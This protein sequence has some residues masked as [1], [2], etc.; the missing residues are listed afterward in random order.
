[1]KKRNWLFILLALVILVGAGMGVYF[2]QQNAA[3]A[4]AATASETTM[5]T[6]AA[7]VGDIT[8][9]ASGAGSIT[10]ATQISLGFEDNG[11]LIELLVEV[12]DKVEKG[13]VMARSQTNQ[14]QESID[15]SIA[16]AVLSILNAQKKLDEL[17]ATA[18]ISRTNAM[19]DITTY[20]QKVRDAQYTLENYTMPTYLQGM[21]AIDAL[22]LMKSNLDA[23]SAAFQP[24]RLYSA[25][26]PVREELL[27]DLAEAQSAYDAAVKRLDYEIVLQVA[28]ANLEKARL[29]Y[30]KYNDGPAA[31]E[32]AI[33]NA[34]L[35]N[36]KAK[37]A[38]AQQAQAV[39]ELIS[40]MDATVMS[41][42]AS[43]GE[44]L[45]SASVITLANLEQPM[46]EVYLDESDLDKAVVGYATQIIFDALPDK[47]FSGKIVAVDPS[48]SSVSNVKAVRVLVQMDD[49]D[50]DVNL[51][52][53]LNASV[54]VVAG[55]A[56]G[57]VLVPVEA[58]RQID[59]DQY[60][61]FVVENGEPLM[62][63]VE[64]GLQDITF[65]E[66]KSG[67]T[68]GETV[69]TGIVQTK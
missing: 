58:L 20:A 6:T 28:Q 16:E 64:V 52:I 29:E 17:H 14:T 44:A 61:V 1:M 21:D 53:G 37:L 55:E 4:Q 11:T 43:V 18:G 42:A 54:D 62:R 33:A 41:I 13:Q 27:A 68:A 67:L 30:D 9:T 31:D 34:E 24:Y 65:A 38:L 51:P 8:L 45:G 32:L 60:A 36:A 46:L 2:F 47:V 40:P 59:A 15:A 23:A 57:V 12:G 63:M 5:Q 48:L 50:L 69:S 22:D 25:D 10:P 35:A 39:E 19:T 3:A 26:N 56:K 49:T 7:R 66:I